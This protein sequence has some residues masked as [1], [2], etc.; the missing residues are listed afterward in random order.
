MVAAIRVNSVSPR[1]S[2]DH[3]TTSGLARG[4]LHDWGSEDRPLSDGNDLHPVKS[5]VVSMSP[6]MTY[7]RTPQYYL[8]RQVRFCGT[9]TMHGFRVIR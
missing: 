4:C 5:R 1:I 8:M 9:Y 3:F 6:C 7:S 2:P